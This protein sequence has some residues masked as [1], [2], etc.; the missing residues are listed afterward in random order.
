MLVPNKSNNYL[1]LQ[2]KIYAGIEN[3]VSTGLQLLPGVGGAI[4]QAIFGYN[5]II[6]LQRIENYLIEVSKYINSGS[7]Q[8]DAIS[9]IEYYINTPEGNEYLFLSL[10][11]AKNIRTKEKIILLKNL[12][13]NH[14]SSDTPIDIDLSEYFL[15]T[16]DSLD[17]KSFEILRF[18]NTYDGSKPNLS[19]E[20]VEWGEES[21]DDSNKYID[22]ISAQYQIDKDD[23]NY[24]H[25]QLINYGLIVD[26]GMGRVGGRPL[27]VFVITKRGKQLIDFIEEPN[28]IV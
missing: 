6:Q 13:L 21:Q 12:F 2:N 23:S 7:I 26:D 3:T 16:I 8:S 14:T 24:Y 19:D 22:I 4:N 25:Q 18:L 11:K 15:N 28:I 9:K 1:T 20:V 27:E 10:D 17:I 5:N